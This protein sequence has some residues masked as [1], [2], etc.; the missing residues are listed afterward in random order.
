VLVDTGAEK[1][2]PEKEG[3]K[4][5]KTKQNKTNQPTNQ[6]QKKKK[7][8]KRAAQR[9]ALHCTAVTAV[10]ARLGLRE[11]QFSRPLASRFRPLSS[12]CLLACE[13]RHP[14]LN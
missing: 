13:L 10:L 12:V 9:N 5:N 2:E 14:S 8:P 11:L 6:Q 4:G 1:K 7:K 3:E